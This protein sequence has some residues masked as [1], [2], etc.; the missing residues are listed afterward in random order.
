MPK[1]TITKV[2]IRR[3]E[4]P[5]H[6]CGKWRSFLTIEGAESYLRDMAFTAPKGGGYD[7]H[8]VKIH[9]SDGDSYEGRIDLTHD[10][11]S[12]YDIRRH[13]ADFMGFLAGV[14]RPAHMTEQQYNSATKMY[15]KHR[16][17]AIEFLGKHGHLFGNEAKT[18]QEE[19]LAWAGVA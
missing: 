2:E 5:S 15:A 8:D 14:H 17:G 4:G 3:G 12:G 10:H 13:V 6:L 1:T 11:V 19:F 18:V 16:A 7:K 9:M